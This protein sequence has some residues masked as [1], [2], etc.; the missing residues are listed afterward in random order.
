MDEELIA[1]MKEW[2]HYIHAHQ[3]TALQVNGAS[4]VIIPVHR[5]D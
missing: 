2:R 5:Y 3:G 1:R 4:I